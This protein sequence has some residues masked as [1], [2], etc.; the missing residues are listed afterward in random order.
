MSGS[1]KP[2]AFAPKFEEFSELWSPKIVARLNDYHVKIVKVKGDFTWHRHVETDE[3]F[4]VV[5]GTLQIDFRDG[6]ATIEAGEMIVIPKG[7][8]HRPH[9]NE[10]CR[11][12][13]IEPA[14]TIN[15]G[16][17]NESEWNAGEGRWL[18]GETA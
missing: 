14:G 1:P 13:L 16:D 11:I 6:A 17:D 3:F 18:D 7:V 12:L 8:E 10:E 2:I 9:A 15:T 5:E 4:L